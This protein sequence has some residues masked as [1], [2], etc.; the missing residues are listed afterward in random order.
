[1]D[2]LLDT[3]ETIKEKYSPH[4]AIFFIESLVFGSIFSSIVL[5]ALNPGEYA[6]RFLFF[7]VLI[8]AFIFAGAR[9]PLALASG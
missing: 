5:A 6:Y 7:Y 8:W 9:K 3:L 2:K 1:M 4:I